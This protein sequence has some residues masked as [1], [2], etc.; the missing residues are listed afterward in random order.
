MEI[1]ASTDSTM[2]SNARQWAGLRTERKRPSGRI[3]LVAVIVSMLS[4]T[5]AFAVEITS[6]EGSARG[7]PALWEPSGNKLAD[8]EFTQW[9]EA[10]R[11]H[12]K[13][14]YQFLSNRRIEQTAEFRQRSDL[15]QD[16]WSWHELR[17]GKL[18]RRF[19]IDF[20]SGR[21]IA[22]KREDP[23]LKSWSEKVKR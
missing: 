4:D 3:Y 20:G 15:I 18:F 8:G 10:E 1:V 6:V 11:L 21:V 13:Q 5:S 7:F 19:E 16:K 17:D 23:Q 22:E 12:V 14:T 2:S 9:L